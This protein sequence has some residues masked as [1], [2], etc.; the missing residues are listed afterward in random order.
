MAERGPEVCGAAIGMVNN[1]TL[2][3]PSARRVEAVR[4]VEPACRHH[5]MQAPAD[6]DATGDRPDAA[7]RELEEP[8]AG[9]TEAHLLTPGVT[10]NWTGHEIIA[11]VT[12]WEEEALKHLL[13]VRE[14]GRP[15]RYSV[16]YGGINAFNA[17]MTAQRSRQ[18]LAE[19]FRQQR[20]V[21]DRPIEYVRAAPE[22]LYARETR[23]HRRPRL[24]TNSHYPIHARAIR[25]WR[26]RLSGSARHTDLGEGHRWSSSLSRTRE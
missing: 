6:E 15:T 17:L 25:N 14:G 16:E 10:G 22:E 21:H 19:E 13:L 11:H 26:A 1:R 23:F 5:P 9:L 8:Y 7:W 3:G 12:W 24:D 20:D 2:G 18:S 4:H